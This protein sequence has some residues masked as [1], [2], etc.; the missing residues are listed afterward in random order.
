MRVMDLPGWVP[1]SGGAHRPGDV[2][3]ISAN[4]VTIEKV[5]RVVDKQVGFTCL[6][7]ERGGRSSLLCSG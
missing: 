2:F 1:Q 4:E 6:F 5:T 7:Q 3:P